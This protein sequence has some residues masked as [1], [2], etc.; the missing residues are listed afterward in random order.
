MT[1]RQMRTKLLR[2]CDELDRAAQ[3]D[4][5]PP[6]RR[7]SARRFLL[8][9][10]LAVSLAACGETPI[11]LPYGVAWDYRDRPADRAHGDAGVDRRV[12]DAAHEQIGL[13]RG[14]DVRLARDTATEKK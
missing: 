9:A 1:D 8:G 13:D 11:Q 2:L 10:S 4:G 6:H 14:G 3:V 7:G 5:L 12:G